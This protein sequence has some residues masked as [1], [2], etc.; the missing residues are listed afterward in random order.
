M[1]PRLGDKSLKNGTS[2]RERPV[3]SGKKPHWKLK[4]FKYANLGDFDCGSGFQPRLCNY[5]Y[6]ATFFRGWKPLP[7][8]MDVKL[9][10]LIHDFL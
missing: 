5:G 4:K 8:E 9:I 1:I 3:R 7:R 6:R 10:T 2:G